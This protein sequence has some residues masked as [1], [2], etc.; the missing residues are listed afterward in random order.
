MPTSAAGEGPRLRTMI[1]RSTRGVAMVLA[2]ALAV[3]VKA[4]ILNLHSLIFC[5]GCLNLSGTSWFEPKLAGS[6]RGC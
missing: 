6:P 2:M 1:L 4:M 5:L 3:A